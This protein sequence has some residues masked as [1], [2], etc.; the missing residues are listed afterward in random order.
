M[1]LPLNYISFLYFWSTVQWGKAWHELIAHWILLPPA[2]ARSGG[3]STLSPIRSPCA[4]LTLIGESQGRDLLDLFD[5]YVPPPYTTNLF[6]I[7]FGVKMYCLMWLL[8]ND[9]IKS[10]KN[11]LL[12]QHSI[13]K[14]RS[15]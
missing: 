3:W 1:W 8:P 6:K 11:K 4:F 2:S 15:R 9:E 12:S 10:R 5:V 14:V 7:A 13:L